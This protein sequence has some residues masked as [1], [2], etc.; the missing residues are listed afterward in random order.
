[1]QD[2][3]ESEE[4]NLLPAQHQA[5]QLVIL[6]DGTSNTVQVHGDPAYAPYITWLDQ[7]KLTWQRFL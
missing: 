2:L 5:R 3:L 4:S 6:C 1:M 7:L